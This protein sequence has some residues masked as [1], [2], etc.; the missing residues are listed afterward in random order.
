MLR[1][2]VTSSCQLCNE[3]PGTLEHRLCCPAVV[4]HDGRPA[5]QKKGPR[6]LLNALDTTRQRELRTR[7]VLILGMPR[8]PRS[9]DGWIRWT[10]PLPASYPDRPRWYIDGSMVDGPCFDTA[11]MGFG[12]ILVAP[13]G[14]VLAAALGAPPQWVL[15]APARKLG[16][17]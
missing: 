9:K 6:Q 5:L 14:S 7:G 3:A 15:N 2:E 10:R 13:D 8:Q 4:P 12:L 16:P 1:E 11:R 17:S